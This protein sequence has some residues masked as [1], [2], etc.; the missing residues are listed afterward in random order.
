MRIVPIADL[1]MRQFT[2]AYNAAYSDYL[3]P[4]YATQQSLSSLRQRVDIDFTASVATLDH[5]DKICGFG[6]LGRR[7][8]RAW[9]SSVAVLSAYRRQG[10]A[11]KM[12]HQLEQNALTNGCTHI[13]LEVHQNNAPAIALYEQ[14]GYHTH[15]DTLT[16][17]RETPPPHTVAATIHT[18]HTTDLIRHFDT[19]HPVRPPW[20]REKSSLA[21]MAMN[22]RGWAVGDPITA[23]IIGTLWDGIIHLYDAAF[24]QTHAQDLADL[25]GTLYNQNPDALCRMMHLGEDEPAWNVLLSLGFEVVSREHEMI[26][27][28][29]G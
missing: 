10:I 13:Q 14:L 4:V 28:L 27:P 21:Q 3:V 19:M 26:K 5:A 24:A 1:D 16:V 2:Q 9:V 15:R 7:D 23:Y 29:T 22:L 8:Q 25:I 6:L 11:R 17:D 18:H 20:Q 12:M